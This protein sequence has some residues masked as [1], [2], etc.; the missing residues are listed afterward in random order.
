MAHEF[1]SGFFTRQPAWH[2]LGVVLDDAPANS[3]EA[4][5]HAGLD[6]H[7]LREQVFF[8]NKLAEFPNRYALVRDS[9][10]KPLEIV[11]NEYEILQ[12]RDA[13][14]FFDPAIESGMARY[15]AAGSLRG[16]KVVWILADLLRHSTIRPGDDVKRYLLLT[17]SH[18][19][20]RAIKVMITSIR[21]VCMNTLEAA[22][23]G[24]TANKIR[25]SGNVEGKLEEVQEM[26]EMVD[27][28]FEAREETYRAMTKIELTGEIVNEFLDALFPTPEY[29]EKMKRTIERI[30][31]D[32]SN[33]KHLITDGNGQ[34]KVGR[35]APATLWDLYNASIEHNDYYAGAKSKD[36]AAYSLLGMGN[37]F[38]NTAIEAAN[39]IIAAPVR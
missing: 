10:M 32:R 9:D 34:E 30:E 27:K 36:R 33:V 18:G 35:G 17:N 19:D 6:W 29:T 37:V 20:N 4:I 22:V 26:M 12:N 8:G 5:I 14:K 25:H 31:R 24:G 16:G 39:D 1:E 3:R 28:E 11:S 7:V 38:R 15:E 23:M 13:F 2:Q 21:V